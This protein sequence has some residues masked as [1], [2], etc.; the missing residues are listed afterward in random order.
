VFGL[1]WVDKFG[2]DELLAGLSLAPAVLAG[3]FL[4]RFATPYVDRS[5]L[6]PAILAITVLSAVAI[7]VRALMAPPGP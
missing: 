4:S 2:L 1:W 7:V 5:S 6:R 3:F